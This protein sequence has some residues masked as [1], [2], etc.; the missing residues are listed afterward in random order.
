MYPKKDYYK[1]VKRAMQHQARL[2][3]GQN[4][5]G[6]GIVNSPSRRPDKANSNA[7]NSKKDKQHETKS[8][9][10][11]KGTDIKDPNSRKV[12]QPETK[13]SQKCTDINDYQPCRAEELAWIQVNHDKKALEKEVKSLKA[14][15][16]KQDNTIYKLESETL[17]LNS[18]NCKLESE[19]ES[20]PWKKL[21]DEYVLKDIKFTEM[22]FRY[23]E[24]DGDESNSEEDSW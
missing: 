16:E 19:I 23:V 21:G 2:G 5:D 22:R 8:S 20:L 12:R 18:K 17:E 6:D 10:S 14:K 13:S 11:K 4:K 1:N 7:P 9:S 15:I 24:N 3:Y